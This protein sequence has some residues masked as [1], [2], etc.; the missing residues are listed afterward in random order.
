[1]TVHTRRTVLKAA[2]AST[3]AV[4]AAGCLGGDAENGGNGDGG[5]DEFKI[6]SG[7]DI[8]LEGSASHWKGTG[9]S[10]ID[11]EENPTLVLTEGEEYTI[12]W[13]NGDGMDH[14]L[15]IRDDSGDVV[16]DL[17]SDTVGEQGESTTL[18][19]TA[20]ADMTTY[21]CGYHEINQVGDLVVE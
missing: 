19:F 16:D 20:H 9:P 1:M 17:I 8:A 13:T 5:S 12:E 14:D 3:I 11:G 18:D 6:E 21:I 10:E 7:T 4:A 2:G 15:Q